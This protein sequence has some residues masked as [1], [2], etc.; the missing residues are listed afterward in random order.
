[1]RHGNKIRSSVMM[2]N[3]RRRRGTHDFGPSFPPV[4]I[5]DAQSSLSVRAQ[6]QTDRSPPMLRRRSCER[7]SR[8]SLSAHPDGR[9]TWAVDI[10]KITGRCC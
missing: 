9:L 7:P 4:H 10:E 6:R 3:F 8:I 5:R 2:P 1:M